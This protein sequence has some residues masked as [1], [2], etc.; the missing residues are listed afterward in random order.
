MSTKYM[1]ISIEDH[2]AEVAELKHLL[3]LGAIELRK[4]AAAYE[5][6]DELSAIIVELREAAK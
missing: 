6:I 3:E 4:L 5:Q 2:E 1:Y